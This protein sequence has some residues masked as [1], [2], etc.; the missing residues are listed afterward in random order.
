MSAMSQT[1]VA[2]AIA[3]EAYP[4]PLSAADDGLYH[5]APYSHGSD[6]VYQGA[7]ANGPPTTLQVAALVAN[8][9]VTRIPQSP[10]WDTTRLA[11][12]RHPVSTETLA[13]ATDIFQTSSIALP[14]RTQSATTSDFP[15][16]STRSVANNLLQRKEPAPKEFRIYHLVIIILVASLIILMIVGWFKRQAERKKPILA[17]YQQPT[18]HPTVRKE[19]FAAALSQSKGLVTGFLA[20]SAKAISVILASFSSA[21]SKAEMCLQ[22][23]ATT[24]QTSS[25]LVKRALEQKI[26]IFLFVVMKTSNFRRWISDPLGRQRVDDN[27]FFEKDKDITSRSSSL[28]EESRGSTHDIADEQTHLDTSYTVASKIRLPPPAIIVKR[29]RRNN[30]NGLKDNVPHGSVSSD[31]VCLED[32]CTASECSDTLRGSE[33]KSLQ[34]IDEC[35]GSGQSPS[36]GL[37]RL[38]VYRIEIE[39]IPRR[40]T[41]LGVKQGDKVVMTRVF[42]D[43]W[44][45]W[46]SSSY[47]NK[48]QADRPLQAFCELLR[49]KKQ[50]LVP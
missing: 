31:T 49:T 33:T 38:N 41:Q 24:V 5:P 39:F 7:Q 35:H 4:T 22:D 14:S 37:L 16:T 19:R 18:G 50:G 11:E 29:T 3:R 1:R 30:E 44:V 47:L 10:V 28:D 42:D 15:V 21:K 17:T 40:D 43:G 34:T 6:T 13:M 2:D 26:R 12:T 20:M 45:G 36:V 32:V 23:G 46:Q 27:A 9:I 8:A 48:D 25:P